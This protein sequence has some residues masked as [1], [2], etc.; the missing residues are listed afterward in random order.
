MVVGNEIG[1]DGVRVLASV[2]PQL[3]Q[4]STL[5]LSRTSCADVDGGGRARWW[6]W[7][8]DS[9]AAH[10]SL[11]RLTTGREWDGMNGVVN[12]LGAAGAGVLATVLLQLTQLSTLRLARTAAVPSTKDR[13][14]FFF[15]GGRNVR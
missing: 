2:L 5:D 1:T 3:P 4:L 10:I 13:R 6:W 8:E 14:D 7:A 9:G 12:S 11:R 15:G